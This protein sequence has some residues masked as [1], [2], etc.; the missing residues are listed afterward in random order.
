[1]AIEINGNTIETDEEGFLVNRADWNQDVAAA[2]AKAENIE[3]TDSHWGLI[4]AA[5]Q[6]F[7]QHQR[8]LTGNDLV[9]ILGKSLK[10]TPH[11]VRHDV[12]NYL[13]QLFPHG[14]EKQIA[15]IA[16]LPKPLPADTE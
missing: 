15:K 16:G 5:R 11:E 10:E 7:R 8:H 14:P 1:M 4:D 12:N 9:H 2:I 3:M 13:Y 6:N